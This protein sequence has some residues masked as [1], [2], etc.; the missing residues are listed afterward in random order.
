MATADAI[1]KPQSA[2]WLWLG[3]NRDRI[4]KDIGSG[5]GSEVAKR[6]G[7]MWKELPDAQKRPYEDKAKEQKDAYD[8]LISTEEGRKALEEKKAAQKDNKAAKESRETE[9]AEKAAAKEQRMNERACSIALKQIPKD[10]QLKKPKSAYWLWLGE[11]REKIA[12]SCTT[13]SVTEVSK[14]GGEMWKSMSEAEKAPYEKKAKAEKAA[15][16][17]FIASDEGKYALQA[18]KD[19]QQEARD[20]YKVS[21]T[22][23]APEED[24]EILDKKRMADAPEAGEKPRKKAKAA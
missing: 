6:A 15:Y 7:M 19:A 1:K 14:K 20:K 5:K 9:R 22:A 2:Y 18:Y 12:A 16:D 21:G 8:K 17:A 10:D 11:N 13:S 23:A 4:S 3:D 24:D